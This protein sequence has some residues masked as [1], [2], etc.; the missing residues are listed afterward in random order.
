MLQ[1][2]MQMQANHK[3]GLIQQLKASGRC[4][5]NDQQLGAM[6]ITTLENMAELARP[7]PDYS[8]MAPAGSS[9]QMHAQANNIQVNEA[10]QPYAAPPPRLGAANAAQPRSATPGGTQAA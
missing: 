2:G 10:D 9:L 7:A 1:R 4:K 3:N 6:D 5:F 8:G